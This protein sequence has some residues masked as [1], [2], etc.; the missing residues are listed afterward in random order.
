VD[1]AVGGDRARARTGVNRS[2]A[3]R[4][5]LVQIRRHRLPRSHSSAH[6][7][8]VLSGAGRP[9]PRRRTSLSPCGGGARTCRAPRRIRAMSFFPTMSNPGFPVR[10]RFFIRHEATQESVERDVTK[11]LRDTL[12]RSP[13]VICRRGGRLTRIRSS[14]CGR[15]RESIT[16]SWRLDVG[17][18]SP[19]PPPPSPPLASP[20]AVSLAAQ[21]L[22][23]SV[24]G[25]RAWT[26]QTLVASNDDDTLN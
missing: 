8:P 9:R 24:R 5:H 4:R 21:S 15:N 23:L 3:G 11:A 19:P 22:L 7:A 10:R 1:P 26:A 20:H 6:P 16:R 14:H 25:A 18:Q 2:A 12:H 17:T 13:P